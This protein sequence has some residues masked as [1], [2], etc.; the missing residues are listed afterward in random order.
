MVDFDGLDEQE[1]TRE[2]SRGS[3]NELTPRDGAARGHTVATLAPPSPPKVELAVAALEDATVFYS[4]VLAQSGVRV[5]PAQHDFDLGAEVLSLHDVKGSGSV[6]SPDRTT[7]HAADSL[8]DV[9]QRAARMHASFKLETPPMDPART[10]AV[11]FRDPWQN[12]VSIERGNR[13]RE[14]QWRNPASPNQTVEQM[15]E[16][17]EGLVL[18]APG[19]P[20]PAEAIEANI[21]ELDLVE[22]V[23]DEPR[24]IR[25]ADDVIDLD[26]EDLIDFVPM[27]LELAELEVEITIE[28]P[29]PAVPPPIPRARA[30]E[31]RKVRSLSRFWIA[32]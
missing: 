11:T 29:P 16:A 1:P 27:E 13:L 6:K 14:W 19:E 31:P 8:E 28:R 2:W 23:E 5:T 9:L 17:L 10:S 4:A 3:S 15:L 24:D 20:T 21:E 22:L 32:N 25:D 26:A 18:T 7:V 12:T 30:A